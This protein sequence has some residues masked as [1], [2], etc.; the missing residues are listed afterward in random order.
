MNK[1]TVVVEKV[2]NEVTTINNKLDIFVDVKDTRQKVL[3]VANAPHPDI[4]AI[5][6]ELEHNTLYDFTFVLASN[7]K[8]VEQN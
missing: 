8:P 4:A 1:Y 6:A 2:S 5:R 3:L 7:Y